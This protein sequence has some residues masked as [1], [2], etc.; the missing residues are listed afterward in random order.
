[1][2]TRP[3]ENKVYEWVYPPEKNDPEAMIWHFEPRLHIASLEESF[4]RQFN[5]P[6]V[7]EWVVASFTRFVKKVVIPLP[8]GGKP[9]REYATPED[10]LRIFKT[11]PQSYGKNLQLA[12]SGEQPFLDEGLLEKNS[13][14]GQGSTS[15]PAGKSDASVE[16]KTNA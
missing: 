15:R 9:P 2:A 3:I 6:T 12:I 8:D 16:K 11:I 7:D 1:M 4:S 14:A 10:I 13:G 5:V